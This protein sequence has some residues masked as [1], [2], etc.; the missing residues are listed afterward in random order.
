VLCYTN[1]ALDQFL[2]SLLK[3]LPEIKDK[4]VRL[5]SRTKD[6]N[7]SQLTLFERSRGKYGQSTIGERCREY[8]I[9]TQQ[10]ALRLTM[11]ARHAALMTTKHLSWRQLVR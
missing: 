11:Q 8:D 7:I 10:D 9:R 5:G 4:M 2:L 1:H 3:E 6:A